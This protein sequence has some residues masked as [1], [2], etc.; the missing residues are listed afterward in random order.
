MISPWSSDGGD[1][2]TIA[3]RMQRVAARLR[4]ACP[5]SRARTQAVNSSCA[6]ALCVADVSTL[7]EPCAR[8]QVR[9]D[10]RANVV[11]IETCNDHVLSD[12]RQRRDQLRPQRPDADPRPV[13]EL[14]VF[15]DP[16]VEYETA[17]GITFIQQ[18]DG[19]THSVIAFLVKGRRRELRLPPVTGRRAWPA[20]TYLQFVLHARELHQ[21]PRG[22]QTDD[23][24]ASPSPA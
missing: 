15:R 24:A 19:I 10:Q 16:A 7:Q 13:R 22:R 2:S 11:A 1:G 12:R 3:R 4:A 5:C 20:N 21:I 23:T 9:N 17:R 8:L 18:A 6:A 14:E